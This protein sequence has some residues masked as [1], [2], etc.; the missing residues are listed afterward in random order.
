MFGPF[1][2]RLPTVKLPTNRVDT[3][4]PRVPNEPPPP[5]IETGQTTA[6]I[7]VDAAG[8]THDTSIV[9]SVL[10]NYCGPYWSNGTLQSSVVGTKQALSDNDEVC[11]IHDACYA[12]GLDPLLC[13]DAL[14]GDVRARNWIR[15]PVALQASAR[16]LYRYLDTTP[17]TKKKT[18]LRKEPKPKD[19]PPQ[20][21]TKVVVAPAAIAVPRPRRPKKTTPLSHGGVRI[22]HS[23]M[24]GT[25][26]S[27]AS[28]NTYNCSN[29]IANPGRSSMFPWLNSIATNYDKY[30]FTRFVARFIP[31]VGTSASGKVGIGFDY[32]SSDPTPANRMEFYALAESTESGVWAPLALNIPCD[33]V[34]RFTNTHTSVDSK[35]IDLGAVMVMT[36]LITTA[37]L[38]VGDL[39]VDY[40]VELYSPQQASYNTDYRFA[41]NKSVTVGSEL[42]FNTVR[43]VNMFSTEATTNYAFKIKLGYGSYSIRVHVHDTAGGTPTITQTSSSNVSGSKCIMAGGT[44][45]SLCH[46]YANVTG[47]DA[48]VVITNV[49]AI[50]NMEDLLVEVTRISPAIYAALTT[51]DG[52]YVALA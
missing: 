2:I 35:L 21:P 45:V 17:M 50:A 15:L 27:S 47:S 20:A 19:K 28:L 41:I 18:N 31:S 16:R 4:T 8:N 9:S 39:V 1:P 13:D 49:I 43:G 7:V 51:V 3:P 46:I 52:D 30:R 6:E 5:V 42:S 14:I 22:S 36:D 29:F 10:G 44:T 48:Y 40:T 11:R 34:I 25:I 24:I 37:S 12:L 32:D 33:N 23:E 38:A 26:I